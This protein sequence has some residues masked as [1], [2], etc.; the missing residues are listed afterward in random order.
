MTD[1]DR[2][3]YTPQTDAPLAFDARRSGGGGRPAPMTLMISGM[4]LVVLVVGVV[5]FYRGGVRPA[6]APPQVIGAPV[7]ADKSA[8]P[9]SEQPADAAAG[10]QVYKSE[11]APLSQAQANVAPKFTPAPEQPEARPSPRPTPAPIQAPTQ[12]APAQS[13]PA[14]A[15]KP[16]VASPPAAKPAV[17]RPLVSKAAT[18]AA[19]VAAGSAAA[20]IGAFS[21][22]ALADKGWNDVA[23][24]LPGAMGGKTKSVE[25]VQR[26]GHTF[27]RT[28]VGGFASRADAARFCASLKAAGKP[29]FVK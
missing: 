24:L 4:V 21:S 23:R 27:Y 13:A 29:C 25:V 6:N 1:N 16:A 10:L 26:D 18:V 2:G 8:P 20:Q 7:G 5:F 28:S 11:S 15:A 9:A 14:P 17:A 19:P 12:L 22:S 3:A